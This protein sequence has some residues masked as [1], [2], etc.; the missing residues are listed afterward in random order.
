MN[1][2]IESAFRAVPRQNFLPPSVAYH[3]NVN[4]PLTIGY[5]QTNSQPETVAMMLEWLEVEPGDSVL[6][7]G[8][9]SGW[10]TALLA[11]LTGAKGQVTAVESVPK[12]VEFGRANCK[13]LN[14]TNAA[15]FEAGKTLGWPDK[16]PYDR[17][18]VS[19]AADE[20]PQELVDQL[21]PEGRMVI[22]VRNAIFIVDKDTDGTITQSKKP[23]FVFV[24]LVMSP[25]A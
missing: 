13:R 15:F 2:A 23:G 10:T 22:P 3:A 24:P 9:G 21:K 17:I 12:L 14:I 4:A 1:P 11:Y 20:L 6:D 25:D 19:A 5:G 16:A 8:S 7:V 18:L